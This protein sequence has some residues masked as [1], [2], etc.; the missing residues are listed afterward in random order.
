MEHFES[1]GFESPRETRTR[2]IFLT[3]SRT[4][5]FA[6]LD[7]FLHF[8][9]SIP[10]PNQPPILRTPYYPAGSIIVARVSRT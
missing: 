10:D 1:P 2:D 4:L 8:L 6:L 3:V 7:F 5:K 9:A